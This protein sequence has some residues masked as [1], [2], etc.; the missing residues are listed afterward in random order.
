MSG[1]SL[2]KVFNRD[3]NIAPIA[4]RPAYVSKEY[5]APYR[6]RRRLED[7]VKADVVF[8]SVQHKAL[9]DVGLKT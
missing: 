3:G 6:Y 7:V 8:R 9:G 4:R 2:E 1:N 5:R